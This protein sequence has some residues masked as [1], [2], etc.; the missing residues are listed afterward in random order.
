MYSIYSILYTLYSMDI[1]EEFTIDSDLFAVINLLNPQY[2]IDEEIAIPSFDKH[3]QVMYFGKLW[4]RTGTASTVDSYSCHSCHYKYGKPYNEYD[5]KGLISRI[6]RD[7]YRLTYISGKYYCHGPRDIIHLNARMNVTLVATKD[8]DRESPIM[9]LSDIR[10]IVI[11]K[12]GV[13]ME[14]S[15]TINGVRYDGISD[16]SYNIKIPGLPGL[17][18]EYVPYDPIIIDI[19]EEVAEALTRDEP[20]FMSEVIKVTDNVD[21]QALERAKTVKIPWLS[22]HDLMLDPDM[23][24]YDIKFE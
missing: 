23:T 18:K 12:N 10:E 6:Y 7:D 17:Y 9:D 22:A 5:E 1:L 11:H 20:Y 8:F 2:Y 24:I 3:N 19:P 21:E 13:D 15:F 4:N 16:D 14:G